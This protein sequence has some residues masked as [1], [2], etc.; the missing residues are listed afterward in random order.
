MT[1]VTPTTGS[2]L[3]IIYNLQEDRIPVRRARIRERL[4]LASPTVT[5]TVNRMADS[6]L[7]RFGRDQYLELTE[8]GAREAV[9]VVRRHRLAERL[10]TD[11]LKM[12]AQQAH[13]QAITWGGM[14]DAD[15]ERAIIDV[16]DDPRQSPWG[17]PVPGLDEFGLT[18]DPRPE[19]SSLLQIGRPGTTVSGTVRSISE[20]AQD[21]PALAASLVGAGIVPGAHITVRIGTD[22]FQLLGLT[23]YD[24]PVTLAHVVKIDVPQNG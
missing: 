18:C 19:P 23:R 9:V 20:D 1:Q 16:L 15:T 14:I 17:N 5:Q 11:V 3:R 12:P 22:C 7:L 10:M 6:G 24:I 4:G 2:F 13:A 21:D 8:T